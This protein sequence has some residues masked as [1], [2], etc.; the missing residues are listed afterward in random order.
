MPVC[1]PFIILLG[2]SRKSNALKVVETQRN[3][4][5]QITRRTWAYK[6]GNNCELAQVTVVT[7]RQGL[8]PLVHSPHHGKIPIHSSQIYSLG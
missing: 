7:T 5:L 6:P 4:P 3:W 2:M 8:D 1:L